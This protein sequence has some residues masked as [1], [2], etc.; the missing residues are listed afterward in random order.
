MTL[1][2]GCL[3]VLLVIASVPAARAQRPGSA[4]RR[5]PSRADTVQHSPFI[6]GGHWRPG[7]PA[8][9]PEPSPDSRAAVLVS[10]I[11]SA[12]FFA[13]PNGMLLR[14]GTSV[15]QLVLR[16]DT[17]LVP[18]GMRT[19][20]VSESMLAG[21]SDWLITESRTGTAIET[22][23]SLHLHRADL[24]PM[25]WTARNGLAQL[26]VSFTPDSM[27]AAVQDYQGR[28]SFAA[29]LPRGA[30]ITSGMLDG[31]LELLPLSAGY[32]TAASVVSVESGA[33][34]AVPATF[35]VEREEQIPIGAQPT[36][37]WVVVLRAGTLEKRFW[38]SKAPQ[39]VVKTEQQT[40]AGL[41]TETLVE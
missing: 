30:L 39:R 14:P 37:C 5:G 22:S 3:G 19:V 35:D 16:R 28:G 23:D 15:F 27:F 13:R 32:H 9:I 8:P 12:G 41:L 18:L 29:G 10:P 38:V 40:S 21:V 7:P 11:D 26:A 4:P 36:D 17:S 34:R 33:P 25:H 1:L 2:R 24:T 6:P 20:S 31:V